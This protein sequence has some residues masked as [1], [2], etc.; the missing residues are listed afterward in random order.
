MPPTSSRASAS[1]CGTT[2]PKAW[3]SL[4][5]RRVDVEVLGH[6]PVLEDVAEEGFSQGT[7]AS[8]T[9]RV[10]DSPVHVHEAIASWGGWSLSATRPGK[11]VRHEDGDEIV[12]ETTVDPDPSTPVIVEATA[13][14]GS[15]PRLRYGRSYAFRAWGVD[16]A[17]NSRPHDL[18]PGPVGSVAGAGTDHRGS[19][20][21]RRSSARPALGA[22]DVAA[23]IR[24]R[25]PRPWS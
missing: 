10:A 21:R 20:R 11:R 6:G 24:S 9:A 2:P 7:T 22:R 17:G 12:E 13:E 18:G 25:P 4:H 1:R 19:R 16:L 5:R 3:F 15:L 8:E 14:P 23:E